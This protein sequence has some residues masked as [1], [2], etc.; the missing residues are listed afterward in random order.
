MKQIRCEVCGSID[1]IKQDGLFVCQSC[2]IQYSLEEVKK[3]MVEGTVKIDKSDEIQNLLKRAFVHL[4]DEEWEEADELFEQALTQDAENSQAYLGKLLVEF[5]CSSIKDLADMGQSFENNRFYQRALKF[6]NEQEKALLTK[7]SKKF[8]SNM[9]GHCTP[10][11]K[12]FLY[13]DS[14]IVDEYDGDDTTIYIPEAYKGKPVTKYNCYEFCQKSCIE[15]TIVLP[16]PLTKIEKNAFEGCQC[17]SYVKIPNSVTVIDNKAFYGVTSLKTIGGIGSGASIEIPASV[18]SIGAGVFSHCTSITKIDIPASVTS[19]G[20]GAFSYCTSI[21]KIDIPTSVTNIEGSVFYGCTALQTAKISS[22][23]EN[24]L[25]YM[26]YGCTSLQKVLLEHLPQN[27]LGTRM[28]LGCTSLKS[29]GPIGSGSSVEIP[30]STTCIDEYAFYQCNKLEKVI[31]PKSLEIIKKGAFDSCTFLKSITIPQGVTTIEQD[32]FQD[33]ISLD[34]VIFEGTTEQ[35]NK[36]KK[37]NNKLN[38]TCSD[39]EKIQAERVKTYRQ[40]H[41]LCVHCGGQFK[42]LFTKKCSSCGIEKDY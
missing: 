3:L 42:G 24:R 18:T 39:T 40:E 13:Q 1:L 36:I 10:G 11:L 32:A 41:N 37:F 2:G 30:D 26:F 7:L 12:F 31:L 35:W 20:A 16:D 9:K 19:I 33:C 6:A 29:V 21:T 23:G 8:N 22:R 5:E 4:E 14:C 15:Y 25:E 17:I 34:S 28:F 38:V 27:L